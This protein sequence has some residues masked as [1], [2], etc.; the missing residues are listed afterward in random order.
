MFLFLF[1]HT[2][3]C[4]SLFMYV[5]VSATHRE[6]EESPESSG[7]GCECSEWNSGHP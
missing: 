1:M 7:E 2:W 3:V 6:P 4:M 5:H